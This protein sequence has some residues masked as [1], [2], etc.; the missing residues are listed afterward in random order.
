MTIKNKSRFFTDALCTS[1]LACTAISLAS[2]AASAQETPESAVNEVPEITV[3]ARLRNEMLQNI[4]ESVTAFSTETIENA[5]IRKMDDF[6]GLTP[7]VEFLPAQSPGNFKI[8]IRGISMTGLG[9]APV[10]M[11]VDDVTLPYPNAFNTP[12][13]DIQSIE[14]LKG[15]QGALY[16][17]NAI[18]GAI[19][20]RTKQPSNAFEG[21]VTASYGAHNERSF[22]G[23]VSGPIVEDVLLFRAGYFYNHFGGDVR[24]A[25]APREKQ[26]RFTE[27]TGRFDLKWLMS[28]GI[29][30]DTSFTYSKTDAGG[31]TLVP[32]TLSTGSGFPNVT[33]EELNEL[34]VLGVPNQ[35][36]HS[37]TS[38][39]LI[40]A[41]ARFA[42]DLGFAEFSWVSAYTDIKET[43]YQDADVASIP[44]VGGTQD[45]TVDAF[46]QELRLTSA[47]TGPFR[48]VV[49]AFG[50]WTD[51]KQP[52]D[53]RANLN[54]ILNG[55][56]DPANQ[57][58]VPA[59]VLTRY[60][61]LNS[62]AV[63]AQIN[64]DILPTLELTVAG[65]YDYNPRS[66]LTRSFAPA[67]A[68]VSLERT[69][70]KFQP[71]TS[72]AY[73]PNTD[74][75]FYATYAEGFRAGGFNASNA[76]SSV[77]PAFDAEETKTVEVGTKF[78]LFDRRLTV[79][80]AGYTTEYANQQ[81][82]LTSTAGGGLVQS[83]FT[84]EKSRIKGV[85]L[86][87]QAR[88][89][90]GFQFGIAAGLQDGEI[91]S[92][93]DSLSGPSFDTSDFVG[94]DVPLLPKYTLAMNAQYSAPI[95][96]S[97]E[98]VLRVDF[99]RKGKLYWYADN[100]YTRKPFNL[101]N[102]KASVQGENWEFG[103]YGRNIFNVDYNVDYF[104]NLFVGAPGGFNF[105]FRGE[106]SRYGAEV[107]Y[108]F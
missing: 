69:F 103:V 19:V 74:L 76:T 94:N 93:G 26:N 61:N 58:L 3:T 46:S 95:S 80:L 92:F 2:G 47:D 50:Q 89:F 33:T 82:T 62:K 59:S 98:G 21:R 107:T 9:E 81:L 90:P 78:T 85:E 31:G 105:G 56:I 28:D 51:R 71:K 100:V 14:V 66:Q 102:F 54:L 41:S 55:D 4:P 45:Q 52:Q 30:L 83:V 64:Y 16:G 63:A 18:G 6:M 15:P 57:I 108:R 8:S 12:L 34:L 37:E 106:K 48:W 70:K 53:I 7:N 17:Q 60:Q 36:L 73:K 1:L 39:E 77:L 75:T 91:K 86:D 96:D 99:T 68:D 84:V 5:R 27:H 29:S 43:N 13:F 88:P 24:Y 65:R 32:E 97:L 87:L 38:R 40:S 10:V 23:T 104:D 35:D 22:I 67:A 20:V 11:V 101:V 44:F 79:A 42:A 72:L 25:Y 49:T